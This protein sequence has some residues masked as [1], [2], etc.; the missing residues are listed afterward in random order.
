[1]ITIIDGVSGSGK[2]YFLT[3]L[4]YKRWKKGEEI[5]SNY[6]LFFSEDS[7][8]VG[9]FLT[10]GET[11]GLCNCTIALDEAQK[12]LNNHKWYLLPL[13]FAEL[14]AGHRHDRIDIMTTTQN[15]YNLDPVMRRNVGGWYRC[16]RVFRFP[17]SDKY[18]PW[19]QWTRVIKMDKRDTLNQDTGWFKSRVRWLFIGKIF[20]WRKIKYDTFGSIDL[21]E[22]LC[23]LQL[24]KNAKPKLVIASR[25]MIN[26]GKTHF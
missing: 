7:E 1:M 3:E 6:K 15:F 23:Q 4:L 25:Q 14:I 16:V 2:T 21:S 20:F 26:S 11:Y 5:K 24:K 17:F 13:N 22:Y 19:L 8:G 10:L 12:L 9:Y 18:H